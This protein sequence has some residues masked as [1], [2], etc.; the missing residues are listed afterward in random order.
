M[1]AMV[2]GDRQIV[3]RQSTDRIDGHTRGFYARRE[4]IPAERGRARMR[5]GRLHRSNNSKIDLEL[6]RMRKLTARVTGCSDQQ[7]VRPRLRSGK[8]CRR[9]MNAGKAAAPCVFDGTV[10][11]HA[12]TESSGERQKSSSES[13]PSC[14]RPRFLA[15]LNEAQSARQRAF[16]AREKFV[17][18]DIVGIR[19]AANRRQRQSGQYARIRRQQRRDIER[20]WLLPR[21]GLSVMTERFADPAKHAEEVE[22]DVRMRVD[23]F[24]RD[25]RRRVRDRDA[26]LL[27]QLACERMSRGFAGLEL[28]AGEFPIAG[29]GLADRTL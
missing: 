20:A 23:E 3:R 4:A 28:A 26:E 29:I 11:E 10:Q 5:G 18:A 16:R 9:P 17:F 1:R 14:R 15:E 7:I 8:R 25:P 24:L 22:L 19:H 2:D 6:R 13:V 27:L 12:R 21:K